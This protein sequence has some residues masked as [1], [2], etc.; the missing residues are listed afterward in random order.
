MPHKITTSQV[1][2][3]LSQPEGRHLEFKEA[4]NQFDRVHD[5]PKYCCALAN[6]GGGALILGVHNKTRAIVGTKAFLG[7]HTSLP[8]DLANQLGGLHVDVDELEIDG[9]RVLVFSVPSRPTGTTIRFNKVAWV[10]FGESCREMQD[11]QYRQILEETQTDETRK[12]VPGV[13]LRDMDPEAL[14]ELRRLWAEAAG[15]PAYLE[16]DDSKTLESL[17]LSEN[18]AVTMAGILL[19]STEST[20]KRF[21]P[22]AEI[23]LE[24][25]HDA[26]ATNYD[27]RVEIRKPFILAI[28]E[29]WREI[30][31]RNVR[32]PFQ[33][34]FVQRQ[35]WAYHEK[36]VREAVVNAFVHRDYRLVGGSVFILFSPDRLVVESPGGLAGGLTVE[37]VLYKKYARNRHLAEVLT[38]IDLMERSG[39][40][41]DDIFRE[42]I[43]AGKGAPIIQDDG[44][45]VTLTLPAA[46]RDAAF[47][48]FIEK[49]GNDVQKSLS[50][51]EILEL[52]NIRCDGQIR[53]PEL[54]KSLLE[55]GLV[56]FFGHGRGVRYHLAKKYYQHAG[57]EAEHTRLTGLDR[58]VKKEYILKYLEQHGSGKKSDFCSLLPETSEID[59]KNYLQE[60]RREGRIIPHGM[61]RLAIWKLSIIR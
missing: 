24:W 32:F 59:I 30:S 56:E 57:K 25:R 39:Q 38:M 11:T 51:E 46:L 15:K 17:G 22:Q 14:R 54:K 26:S 61:G 31:A 23:V 41:I 52:E 13:T 21:V 48:Q 40:G 8:N 7:N 1:V 60:L 35:V 49:V 18:G 12:P 36:S 9:K 5:L 28:R 3:W 45:L 37:S 44:H 29:I 55:K 16:F 50:F 4:K 53:N 19:V 42:S 34:G 47:V 58:S 2:D 43:V 33:E 27:F 6:E 10:R 20:L